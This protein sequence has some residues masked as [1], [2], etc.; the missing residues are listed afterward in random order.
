MTVTM[1][2]IVTVTMTMTMFIPS[3]IVEGVVQAFVSVLGIVGNIAC[4][5]ILSRFDNYL[6]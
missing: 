3:I 4:I 6:P 1:T 2:V 5:A